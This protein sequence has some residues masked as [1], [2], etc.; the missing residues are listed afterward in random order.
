MARQNLILSRMPAAERKKLEPYLEV[1]HLNIKDQVAEVDKP[2]DYVWFPHNCVTSTVVKTDG[3]SFLEVG[4]MGAEGMAGLSLLFGEETS[5]TTVIVQI[6]GDATRMRAKDFTNKVVAAREP[7]FQL[8]QKYCN[9]FMAMLAQSAVCNSTHPVTE[10]M[11]RWVLMT[12]DRVEQDLI[13]L[14]HEFLSMMLGIPP[15]KVSTTADILAR[16]RLIDFTTESITIRDRKGLE[17]TSCD[18]YN[19]ITRQLERAFDSNWRKEI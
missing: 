18:C 12:H 5:N 1:V 2:L 4:L 11:C 6:A 19:V 15:S 3:G 8:V 14:N 9:A 10:R 16:A 13:P 17:E 7:L